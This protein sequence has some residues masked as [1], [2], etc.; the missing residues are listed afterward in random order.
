MTHRVLPLLLAVL[1]LVLWAGG[2]ALAEDLKEGTHTGKVVKAAGGKLT[3][4]GKDG[5]TEHSHEVTAD[6][7]ITCDGKACKL[8]DL[9]K[10]YEVTVTIE[11]RAGKLVATKL[12][13]KKL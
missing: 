9:L 12:E 2:T 11:K 7:K 4:T 10:G 8:E 5:K 3:M 6:A 1:A 13:G